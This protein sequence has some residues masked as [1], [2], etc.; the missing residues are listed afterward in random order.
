MSATSFLISPDRVYDYEW[1]AHNL[2]QEVM[3]VG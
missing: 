3:T 2:E 1:L